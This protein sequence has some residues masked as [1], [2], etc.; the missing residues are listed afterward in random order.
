MRSMA[1]CLPKRY[2]S[3]THAAIDRRFSVHLRRRLRPKR[4]DTNG[5]ECV[6][7][8]RLRPG[9]PAFIQIP[10][11]LRKSKRLPLISKMLC[12]ANRLGFS[13][14]AKVAMPELTLARFIL[15][16]S[17]MNYDIISLSDSK[18]ASACLFMALRLNHKAGWNKTLEYYSGKCRGRAA[19]QSSKNANRLANLFQVISSTILNQLCQC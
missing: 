16:F 18:I 7:H 5:D 3:G 4:T 1:G 8:H 2:L 10:A 19:S 15:E 9:H 14:C 11:P 17:L 13:Q 12:F 6:P